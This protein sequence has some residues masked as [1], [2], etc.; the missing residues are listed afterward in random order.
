MNVSDGRLAL[1]ILGVGHFGRFHALKASANPRV[2]LVGLHDADP[3]RAASVAAETGTTPMAPEALIG[4]A[5][6]LIVAAPTRFHFGL[7]SAALAA[8]R[9]VFVEKPI[10]ATLD[11]ADALIAAAAAGRRVLQV[12][13][14]ERFSAAFRAVTEAPSG[15]RALSWDAVRAAP[16]RPRSLDVSVVLD[17]MIHDLDLVMDLAGGEPDAV[18]AVG[19]AV[20]SQ[21]PDFAVARLRFPGG[22]AAVLTA[23]RVSLAMERRLRVLGTEGEMSV[24]FLERSLAVM[25]R[26]GAEP[27][28]TMPG[29]GI[30]RATWTD[31]DS[32][33]AEQAAFV[34]ACLDGAPVLVDGAA[35]RRALKVALAVE[36]AI[37]GD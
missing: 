20:V 7:G 16:F 29:S 33:E 24:N 5:D 23:S 22:R 13:H 18:E 9:H 31:H 21:H 28:A 19:A 35:G 15:G 37:R 25:R 1:G 34:A 17:L 27:V 3:A 11:E 30:D 2:R 14:I 32:L 36:A 12:G 8:G 4:A 26:G 10:A 6:A